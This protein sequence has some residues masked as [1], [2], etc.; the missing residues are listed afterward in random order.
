ML[1]YIFIAKNLLVELIAYANYS[2]TL[3]FKL[4]SLIAHMKM[5]QSFRL[6]DKLHQDTKKF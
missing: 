4:T 6:L 3:S 1:K 2:S 5:Y